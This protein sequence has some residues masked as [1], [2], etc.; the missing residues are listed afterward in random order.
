MENPIK[1]ED[2][3]VPLFLETSK[4]INSGWHYYREG[5]HPNPPIHGPKP[6]NVFDQFLL[7]ELTLTPVKSG[8]KKKI[9]TGEKPY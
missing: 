4:C 9:M 7:A 1:I 8:G 2:L 6:Q 3:G 5:G